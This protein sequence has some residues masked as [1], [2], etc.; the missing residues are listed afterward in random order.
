VAHAERDETLLQYI[1]G[2]TQA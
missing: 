2:R 1:A